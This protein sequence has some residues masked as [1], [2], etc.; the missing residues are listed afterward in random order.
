MRVVHHA[1]RVGGEAF[2][3]QRHFHVGLAALDREAESPAE[4][5]LVLAHVEWRSKIDAAAAGS[6]E[7][8]AT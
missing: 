8:R 7:T 4:G 3:G 6:W 5:G 2:H 1:V